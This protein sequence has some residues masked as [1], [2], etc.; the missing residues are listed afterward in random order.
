MFSRGCG[1]EHSMTR[2]DAYRGKRALAAHLHRQRAI[3]ARIAHLA[4]LDHQ[5]SP[6]PKHI[7]ASKHSDKL[8]EPQHVADGRRMFREAAAELAPGRTVS[9][10]I[11][12][13]ARAFYGYV[14]SGLR[15]TKACCYGEAGPP[16]VLNF[17]YRYEAWRSKFV[18]RQDTM[19]EKHFRELAERLDRLEAKVDSGG[20]K[21]SPRMGGK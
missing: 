16:T 7:S 17:K 1:N 20:T 21:K 5:K 14:S 13:V 19:A 8:S 3:S 6:R 11:R 10:Q 12:A 18:A 2:L 9:T 15:R 4:A